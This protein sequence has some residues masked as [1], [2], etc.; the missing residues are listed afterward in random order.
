MKTANLYAGLGDNSLE[1][2]GDVTAVEY[3]QA[4]TDVYQSNHKNHKVFVTD[5]H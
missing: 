1:W 3:T 4:I 5:A 2:G